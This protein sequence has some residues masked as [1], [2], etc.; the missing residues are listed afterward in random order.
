MGYPIVGCL[1]EMMKN[2]PTFRWIHQL[3]QEM[4]T[5][6]ACIRL[7]NTHVIPVTSPELAREFLRK[8]DVV[9]A[10]RP[11]CMSGKLTSTGYLTAVLS[12]MGDQW[13]KM[14]RIVASEVLSPTM[15]RWLY[16]KRCEEADHLIK[17]VYKQSQNQL[18][19]GLVNVRIA[20][21]LY[22]GNV[23]RKLMFS[24]RFFG[25]GM[26]GGGPGLEEE[27]HVDGLF[28]IL[29]YLYG[30][31]IA[32]YL[33]WLEVF[34]L[35]GHK[36]ILKD[37]IKSV[38]KYQDPEI[39]KRIEMWKQGIRKTEE[40]LLDIT[41]RRGCPAIVL[42]STMTVILLARLIQGFSWSTPRDGPSN[43]IDLAESKEDLSMAKPFISHAIPR[44]EPHVYQ[45]LMHN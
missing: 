4:N 13:K 6:I 1:P 9:F 17:Y 28:T 23:I 41:G 30:F 15:N 7:G 44:L 32:D 8:Q 21:Q 3:M 37:A 19:N 20:A 10:S 24:K 43:I 5:E 34:D 27:E 2:K 14:R 45:K 40:D 33:P 39:N 25:T 12:P 26:E 31:G 22:C 36:R 18:T 38:R 11:D 29:K 35:D 42:G 16:G